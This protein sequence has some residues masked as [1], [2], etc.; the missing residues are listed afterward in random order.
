[1]IIDAHLHAWDPTRAEYDWLSEGMAPWNR[2]IDLAEIEPRLTARSIDGVVLVQ[3]ADNSADTRV[4]LDLARAH[5]RVRGVVGWAALGDAGLP[6]T[7]ESYASEPLIVGVRSLIHERERGWIERPHVDEG[8]A[9]IARSGLPLD[10]PTARF[11]ELAF[12]PDIAARHPDLTLVIDHLGKP[13]LG[14]GP[15]ALAEW[16]DLLAAAAAHPRVVAKV[17]GLYASVGELDGWRVDDVH[18]AVDIALDCFG[19]DRL[20]YGGDWPIAEL[21]GGYARTWE[22]LSSAVDSLSSSERDAIF[23]ETAERVYGLNTQGES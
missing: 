18:A 13:P 6:A 17:S 2:R 9:A 15:E 1:M 11:K 12:V 16:R 19:P 4:M 8:V 20:M 7:L 22:A 21:A 10:Y 3:A 5:S 23:G 14:E